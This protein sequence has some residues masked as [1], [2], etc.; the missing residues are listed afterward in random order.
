MQNVHLVRSLDPV[1]VKQADPGVQLKALLIAAQT[2]C[3]LVGDSDGQVT[4]YEIKNLKMGQSNQ[5][6][7]RG[8]WS[9][10]VLDHNPGSLLSPNIMRHFSIK[11]IQLLCTVCNL[12]YE[13]FAL[14]VNEKREW[15]YC[16]VL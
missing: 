2:D 5:V 1:I 12:T 7:L 14:L 10:A 6:S 8:L 11:D 13:V 4:V 16:V 3:V 15:Y 9:L